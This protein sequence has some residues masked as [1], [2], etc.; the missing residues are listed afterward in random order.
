MNEEESFETEKASFVVQENVQKACHAIDGNVS[1]EDR[2]PGMNC[3]TGLAKEMITLQRKT[4]NTFRK[5]HTTHC[6]TQIPLN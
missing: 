4:V 5:A 2:F 1:V 6:I 3:P